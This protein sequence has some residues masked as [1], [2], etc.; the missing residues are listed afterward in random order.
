MFPP[1]L[2]RLTVD[3][4]LASQAPPDQRVHHGRRSRARLVRRAYASFSALSPFPTLSSLSRHVMSPVSCRDAD[5]RK[6]AATATLVNFPTAEERARGILGVDPLLL[7]LGQP[8]SRAPQPG[9]E[10]RGEKRRRSDGEEERSDDEEGG[11]SDDEEGERSDE[12]S[13][14]DGDSEEEDRRASRT[15]TWRKATEEAH[16]YVG[17]SVHH[18]VSDGV[19]LEKATRLSVRWAAETSAPR[20]SGPSLHLPPCRLAA[21]RRDTA[22]H[23]VAARR[24]GVPRDG[25]QDRGGGG[26]GLVR[27]WARSKPS[28]A[29]SWLLSD[30][31]GGARRDEAARKKGITA[32][33]FP[34]LPGETKG[35]LARV[36]QS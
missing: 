31:D 17:V 35:G 23:V 36:M 21:L 8:A 28:A 19:F 1:L 3:S 10:Q 27:R 13:D 34:T 20:L 25:L 6:S 32:V 14:G 9:K 30:R 7:S 24:A 22:H 15:E 18:T 16:L 11:R 4:V 29:L 33:N 26:D 2:L 12:E 5:A